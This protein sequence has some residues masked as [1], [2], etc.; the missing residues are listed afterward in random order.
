MV[1]GIDAS[2]ALLVETAGGLERHRAGTIRFAEEEEEGE[3][4]GES[5]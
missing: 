4:E 3:G 5:T 1:T 2:G